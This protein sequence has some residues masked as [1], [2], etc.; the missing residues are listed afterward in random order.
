MNILLDFGAI[1][2][3]GGA[4]LALNFL[5]HMKKRGGTAKHSFFLLIPETG[6]LADID[7]SNQYSGIYKTPKPYFR[8]IIFE[9]T[10][11][12][13]IL[14]TNNIQRVYTFFGAGIP[15][16]KGI[17]SIVTVAYPIICYPDSPYWKYVPLKKK[18]PKLVVNYF[19]RKRLKASS[20][21]IA[22][23]EVMKER[24]IRALNY[25]SQNINIIPPA[26]SEYV[27]PVEY[28]PNSE[29]GKF[30][31]LSGCDP[32]KNLW[33]LQNLAKDFVSKGW[34]DFKF[35]LTVKKESYINSL[36]EP[37]DHE[38]LNNHF[39]FVGTIH[40]RE[41]QSVY[42][43]CDFLMIPSDLESFSNN[44]MEAWKA[45]IPIIASNRDFA[46]HICGDSAIYIEPHDISATSSKLISVAKDNN[47]KIK[48][49]E[50][51]KSKLSTLHNTSDRSEKIL[52][53]ILS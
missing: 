14:K 10:K 52:D 15:C 16:P 29:T 4:Q 33:I 31:F 13:N 9:H 45:G 51:G 48:L 43:K 3:G 23:T 42:A 26:P 41:I 36:K 39:E 32:H 28:N 50:A 6:P 22:E 49:I 25:N 35:I 2:S 11:L 37:A 44:Y 1:V 34:R 5:D 27:S 24:L 19:R 17:E 38:I 12:Q 20:R 40:P 18:Y 30:L 53:I 47:L 21:I 8:R 7:F 46:K